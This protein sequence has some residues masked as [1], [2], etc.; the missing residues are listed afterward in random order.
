MIIYYAILLTI[1]IEIF[2]RR[3][4]QLYFDYLYHNAIVLSLYLIKQHCY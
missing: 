2:I 4:A 1:L 3:T